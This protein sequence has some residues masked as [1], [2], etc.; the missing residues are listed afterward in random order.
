MDQT[1]RKRALSSHSPFHWLAAGAIALGL[2]FPAAPT[3]AVAGT[4]F[5]GN[6]VANRADVPSSGFVPGRAQDDQV[7][8]AAPAATSFTPPAA[9]IGGIVTITGTELISTT[10]VLFGGVPASSFGIVAPEVIT[11]AVGLG[12][13][14]LISITSPAGDTAIPGFTYLSATTTTITSTLP[15]PVSAG[16]VVTVSASVAADVGSPTGTITVAS[17]SFNCTI[18]APAGSCGLTFPAA[19]TRTVTATYPATGSFLG[20]VSAAKT[21]TVTDQPISNLSFDFSPNSTALTTVVFTPT[22]D[23]GTSVTYSWKF[24]DEVAGAAAAAAVHTTFA[25]GPTISHTYTQPGTYTVTVTAQNPITTAT[26]SRQ[27]SV[28]PNPAALRI[29]LPVVCNQCYATTAAPV[30]PPTT[31]GSWSSVTPIGGVGF[32]AVAYSTQTTVWAVGTGG[33]VYKSTDGGATWSKVTN[34][35]TTADLYGVQ[36]PSEQFGVII[37]TGGTIR[38]TTDGGASWQTG[39]SGTGVDLGFGISFVDTQTGWV[40]GNGGTILKTT[41]GGANWTAQNTGFGGDLS[42]V[43]FINANQGWA[44][45][46]QGVILATTNGGNTWTRQKD[47]TNDQDALNRIYF[48]DSQNGWAVG[49]PNT[50][51]TRSNLWHTTNGGATWS[52]VSIP[53][54]GPSTTQ[55]VFVD[56]NRAWISTEERYIL[57]TTNGGTSWTIE[58]DQLKPAGRHLWLWGIDARFDGSAVA[59]GTVYPDNGSFT[60]IESVIMRRSAGT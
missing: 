51:P 13:S 34:V 24:G 14:G 33:N 56:G 16:S 43:F 19:G 26:R 23:A 58:V 1:E 37:G 41:N 49:D 15:N 9:P 21:I 54:T 17:G 52:R 55:I 57:K 28:A 45:G 18:G 44:A 10:G 53:I 12:A 2:V 22:I 31:P 8:F 40:S 25:A 3:P 46:A 60:P 48:Q 30:P 11:A 6:G 4:A 20:S 59:V 5:A 50:G 36:F 7:V 27:V 35:N 39:N 42:G 32:L 38:R 47:P 29:N